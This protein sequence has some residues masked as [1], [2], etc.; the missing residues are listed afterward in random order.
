MLKFFWGLIFFIVAGGLK[1]QSIE[2]RRIY[3]YSNKNEFKS[4]G[5]R[6]ILQDKYGFIWIAAQDGLYRFDGRQFEKYQSNGLPGHTLLGIDVRDE[7]I[8]DNTLWVLSGEGGLNAIDLKSGKI[9][10]AINIKSFNDEDWNICMAHTLNTLW[11]GRFNGLAI[12]N[13][14]ENT[15]LYDTAISR[16]VDN[17]A[18]EVRSILVDE[19]EKVWVSV[20]GFGIVIID[21]KSGM[22]IK[23]IPLLDETGETKKKG[24]SIYCSLNMFNGVV[25][26]GTS[27]GLRAITFDKNYNVTIQKNIF[28]DFPFLNSSAVLS[29]CKTGANNFLFSTEN[30]FYNYNS[31]AKVLSKIIE[32]KEERYDDWFGAV[33]TVFIDN[34][35]TAWLG[36][37]NGLAS[38]RLSASPF[39]SVVNS[40]LYNLSHVYCIFPLSNKKMLVGA[41]NG[42]FEYDS[43]SESLKNISN[44]NNFYYI[45]KDHIGSV[46]VSSDGGIY[47]YENSLLTP[48]DKKYPELDSFAHFTINSHVKL[49]DSIFILGTDNFRGIVVWNSARRYADSIN[50]KTK[51]AAL[52]ASVVN[53]IYKDKKGQLWVL[54]DKVITVLNNSLSKSIPLF[55]SD[56]T[57]K[58][59]FNIYFDI[60]EA[61]NSY[62]IAAYGLGIIQLDSAYK[63][64]RVYTNKDGLCDNGVYKM[65][66][67]ADTAL[68]ITTNNGISV[69]NI[70]KH[71]FRNYYVK[72]GL[73]SDYF[74]EACGIQY[75]NKIYAGGV[76]GFT[77][78]NPQYF[79]ANNRPP[80]FYFTNIKTEATDGAKDT[81]NLEMN[82]LKIPNTWLQTNVSFVGLN[83]LNPER[84]VYQYRLIGRN[85]AWVSLGT[86]NFVNIIGLNPGKY[87]LEVKAAN[88]EGVWCEPKKLTLIILP[89]WYQTL[90]F[91]FLVAM[92]VMGLLY[93]FFRYRISQIKKQQQM[94]ADI[95]ND[96]H[97]DIGSALNSVKF[98]TH[99]AQREEDKMK[100]INQIEES[101]TQAAIGLR[102]MLWI[103]DDNQDTVQEILERI[104]KFA[105]P[106]AVS[107]GITL[108]FINGAA[109]DSQQ[110]SSKTKKRNLLLIAKESINNSLKYADCKNIK[111]MLSQKS[112]KVTLVI[113]D[114]GK[115][116]DMVTVQKGYGLS[117]IQHRAKQIKAFAE[118]VSVQGLGT[119]VTIKQY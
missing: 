110:I 98:F 21:S 8:I 51:P 42:L 48:I 53:V 88:E 1:G 49:N 3:K 85:N 99:L 35:K 30:G 81:S 62:W 56:T 91:D 72:D 109:G 14:K 29:M 87:I 105:L 52:A 116:F 67:I 45:F 94:R 57:T 36:C 28:G 115:G 25:Y 13:I 112:N 15:I 34:D 4:Y 5:I 114:D 17:K 2:V 22:L 65:F 44:S 38:F 31:A 64:M 90:W 68:L 113:K 95:A 84:V 76:N 58:K 10:K 12:Y 77:I 82:E 18:I 78:I 86:Q 7:L 27:L 79:A 11:I 16:M 43:D 24:I 69:F 83:Y 93:G 6:K 118:I 104:K 50:T 23:K 119:T 74:E 54:G 66:S 61:Q 59:R 26:W 73:Q 9:V 19:N 47:V 111:V 71:K 41:K 96:L 80:G 70:K 37:Q 92:G 55:Y 39:H 101:I 103:L 108:D 20:N 40:Q 107:N 117:N 32:P 106:L 97:D 60:V 102:D 75:N 46:I 89:K 100:H 63:I 33:S